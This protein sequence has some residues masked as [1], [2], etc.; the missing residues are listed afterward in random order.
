MSDD[1]TKDPPASDDAPSKPDG[2]LEQI[3]KELAA[4]KAER[5][6]W[7]GRFE[8]DKKERDAAKKKARE[9]AERA[10]EYEKV[11]AELKADNEKLTTILPEYEALKEKLDAIEKAQ[12]EKL[13]AQIPEDKRAKFENLP[14]DA[15]EAAIELIPTTPNVA[16]DKNKPG[17]LPKEGSVED[18]TD[19]EFAAWRIDKT[20][21][22]KQRAAYARAMKAFKK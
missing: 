18:M 19:E 16:T 12:R 14:N 22:E 1:I 4:I 10:G 17:V 9:E 13:L 8:N 11:L 5:D 21:E 6:D 20:P 2:T 15:I 7:K 3:Q